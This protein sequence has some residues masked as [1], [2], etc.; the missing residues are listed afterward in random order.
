[1][2][3][4]NVSL[5]CQLN[6]CVDCVQRVLETRDST[7][8]WH[9]LPVTCV[10]TGIL[11]SNIWRGTIT[12]LVDNKRA[13]P[14]SRN[15]SYLFEFRDRMMTSTIY[16]QSTGDSIHDLSISI[17]LSIYL[18]I[19]IYIYI[20]IYIRVVWIE[21]LKMNVYKSFEVLVSHKTL[22]SV[23]TEV[24]GDCTTSIVTAVPRRA[25]GLIRLKDQSVDRSVST[26]FLK[27]RSSFWKNP[28][29]C[30]KLPIL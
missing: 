25:T 12:I 24:V 10:A 30:P 7:A 5:R 27:I 4:L 18:S 3:V 11:S 19:Y 14:L 16:P 9:W 26:V 22:V 2:L 20:Y 21:E 6:R 1:M 13:F 15:C 28:S 23:C 17:Y 8:W 29:F